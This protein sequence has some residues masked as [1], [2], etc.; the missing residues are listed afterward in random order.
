[1]VKRW[2]RI[3]AKGRRTVAYSLMVLGVA[4]IVYFGCRGLFKA[5]DVTSAGMVD[6]VDSKAQHA[7]EWSYGGER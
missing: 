2:Y 5:M 7:V 4:F 3:P 1:M 6:Q